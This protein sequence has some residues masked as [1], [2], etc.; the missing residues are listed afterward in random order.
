V[1]SYFSKINLSFNKGK[2]NFIFD[3]TGIIL[4]NGVMKLLLESEF[5]PTYKKYAFDSE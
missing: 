3:S 5:A 1:L 4:K 2:N